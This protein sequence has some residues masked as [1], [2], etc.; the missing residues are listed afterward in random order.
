MPPAKPS[1]SGLEAA[2]ELPLH[3]GSICW[4]S[5]EGCARVLLMSLKRLVVFLCIAFAVF[6]VIQA[7]AEAAKLVRVTGEHAGDWFATAADSL[8]KFVSSLI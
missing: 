8:S 2:F 4:F 5:G 7:P 1:G 6:F 3:R